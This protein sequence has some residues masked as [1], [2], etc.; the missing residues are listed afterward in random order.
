MNDPLTAQERVTLNILNRKIEMHRALVANNLGALTERCFGASDIPL[1][2]ASTI[3][4]VLVTNADAFT[5]AL[6]P[7]CRQRT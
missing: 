2:T 7:Y 6:K 5:S 1:H 4:E 3:M